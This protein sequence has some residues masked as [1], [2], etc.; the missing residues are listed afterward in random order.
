MSESEDKELQSL[1]KR[2]VSPVNA[3]L[4]RDLWPAMLRRLDA[5]GNGVPW[6]DWLIMGGSLGVLAVFP[7]LILLLAYNF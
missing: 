4:G 7:R 3:E 6:Y 1:L 2:A 5:A